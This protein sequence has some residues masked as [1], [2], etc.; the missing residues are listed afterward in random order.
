MDNMSIYEKG[1]NLHSFAE[2]AKKWFSENKVN[3]PSTVREWQKLSVR[4]GE[5]PPG[6]GITSLRR[7]GFNCRELIGILTGTLVK[8]YN[9]APVTSVSISNIGL[10]WV[11]DEEINNHKKVTIQCNNCNFIETL[12]YETL[13]RMVKDNDKYCRICRGT[14][15]KEKPL[16]YYNVFKGFLVESKLDSRVKYTCNTC[17]STIERTVTTVNTAEFIVCEIC[18]PRKNFG[19]RIYTE[20]GYFDSQIE[21][22]A[23]KVLL[24]YLTPDEIIRQKKYD[25]LFNTETKHTADFFIPK[26]NLVLEVTTESNNIGIKYNTTANWKKEL[27]NTVKFAYSLKQVEDI[28]QSAMKIVE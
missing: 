13:R 28:V 9:Y 26:L 1:D 21:Y 10:T 11:S 15:G 20:L 19:A 2:K 27:S 8:G 17:K 7:Y 18:H 14:G 4:K 3:I 12:K 6:A 24:K 22:K 25:E 5:I 16:E 23:Y